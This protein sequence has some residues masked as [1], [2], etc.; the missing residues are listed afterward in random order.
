M[1]HDEQLV[2]ETCVLEASVLRLSELLESVLEVSVLDNSVLE[3][4]VLEGWVFEVSV[5]EAGGVKVC[6]VEPGKFEGCVFNVCDPEVWGFMGSSP[7]PPSGPDPPPPPK[8]GNRPP[9][10]TIGGGITTPPAPNVTGAVTVVRKPFASVSTI[11]KVST[12]GVTRVNSEETIAYALSDEGLVIAVLNG[13]VDAVVVYEGF[14][15]VEP[16]EAWDC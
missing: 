9:I 16:G 3:A 2:V 6:V 11:G 5:L 12:V 1:S 8:P 4:I 10:G 7:D 13:P 14:C 15:P